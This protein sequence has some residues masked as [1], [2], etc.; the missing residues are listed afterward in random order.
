LNVPE[1]LT[2][3]LSDV[4]RALLQKINAPKEEIEIFT[5]KINQRRSNIMFDFEGL[6]GYDVQE[7]RR[8]VRA[9]TQQEDRQKYAQKEKA[10]ADYLRSQGLSDDLING[11]L[12]VQPK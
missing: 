9:E 12:S 5:E 7:T 11:A 4:I 3:L 6:S 10:I 8:Q 1:S 2:K